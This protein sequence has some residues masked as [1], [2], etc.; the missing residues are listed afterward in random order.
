M[1]AFLALRAGFLSSGNAVARAAFVLPLSLLAFGAAGGCATILGFEDTTLAADASASDPDDD[2]PSDGPTDAGDV[3]DADKAVGLYVDPSRIT[4]SRGGA[5][6]TVAISLVRGTVVT[7]DVTV[8][9]TNLAQGLS[10]QPVTIQA[11][12]SAAT[13]SIVATGA[14]TPGTSSAQIAVDGDP[15]PSV[16]LEVSVADSAG[17]RDPGFGKD[18]LVA[19]ESTGKASVFYALATTSDAVLAGG[20]KAGVGWLLRRYSSK[21]VLDATFTPD[22]PDIGV[23]RAIAVD[24]AGHVVCAGES[25]PG[26]ASANQLTI[27]RFTKAGVIDT[28]FGVGGIYRVSATDAPL[29][30]TGLAIAIGDGD[31]VWVAGHRNEASS[32]SSGVLVQIGANGAPVGS[33][34]AGKPLFVADRAFVGVASDTNGRAVVAGS[35]GTGGTSTFFLSRRTASGDVDETFGTTGELTFGTGFSASAFAR[36]PDGSFV[37]GG[38]ADNASRYVAGRATALGSAVWARGVATGTSIGY[39]GA[40]VQANGRI[41]LAGPSSTANQEGRV[42]RLLADGSLDGAFGKGG[43]SYVETSGDVSLFAASVAPD[44]RILVAGNRANLGPVVYG[45]SP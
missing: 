39:M 19:D 1:R 42:D 21:G 11:D 36:S 27:A 5:P 14:A 33:F 43:T 15:V 3:P 29:G 28:T 9:V 6:A 32:K 24:S 16:P 8:R 20:K 31:S 17:G 30:S 22:V 35:A 26:A 34:N 12:R 2:A 4:L 18:G 7:G 23:L 45:L 40:A 10:S 41:V 13:L 25:P 38:A 37:L 44:G